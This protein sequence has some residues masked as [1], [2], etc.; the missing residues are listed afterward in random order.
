MMFACTSDV[1]PAID[2]TRD[3]RNACGQRP[4]DAHGRRSLDRERQLVDALREARPEELHDRR[5]RAGL[6][7]ALEAR[8]RAAVQEPH[9]LDVD[10]GARD[11]LADDGVARARPARRRGR[12]RRRARSAG[13]PAP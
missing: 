9:D 3:Q 2:D 13:A 10:V 8:Q 5:L 6:E 7:A 12:A 11:R 4:S 1:P